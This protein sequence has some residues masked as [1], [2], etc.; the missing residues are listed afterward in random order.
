MLGKRSTTD[1]KLDAAV[2]DRVEGGNLLGETHGCHSG[3]RV[4]PKR[5]LRVRS[6]IAASIRK[7]AESI[8]R[9]AAKRGSTG[10]TDSKPRASP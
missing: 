1:A 9:L 3:N 8:E 4:T 10:H 7:G 6:A 5:I 2:A